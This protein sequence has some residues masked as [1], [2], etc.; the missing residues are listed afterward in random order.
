MGLAVALQNI[1][2]VIEI[3]RSS[4]D[5]NDA[6]EKLIKFDWVLPNDKFI[7]NFINS[8]NKDSIKNSS[9]KLSETQARSILEIRLSKLTNLERTKL[10]DDLKE[11]VKLIE[12]YLEILSSSDRLNSVMINELQEIEKKIESP[13]RTNISDNEEIID[14][15]SLITSEDVVVTLTNTGYIKRV[16]LNSYRS[17]R[18][19]GK[20]RAGMTTKEEDFV[21]EVFVVNTLTPLL[22]SHQWG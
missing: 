13:R 22:F 17:Q 20:G 15:E 21:N 5:T 8:E 1:D 9:F 14:D 7:L 19:G 2:K 11:C 4:S 18:R 3:I 12:D 10:S 6:R 16:P